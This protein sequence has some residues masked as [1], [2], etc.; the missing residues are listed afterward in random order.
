MEKKTEAVSAYLIKNSRGE[1]ERKKRRERQRERDRQTDRQTDNS[2]SNSNSKT[3]FY[4]N[5]RLG[6]VKNFHTKYSVLTAPD[7]R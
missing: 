6:S 3:L 2:N 1:G 7:A 5:C 4:K